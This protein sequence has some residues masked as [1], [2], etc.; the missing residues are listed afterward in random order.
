MQWFQGPDAQNV[1][2]PRFV[3]KEKLATIKSRLTFW[4]V[5]EKISVRKGHLFR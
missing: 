4:E 2:V 1:V 3:E 5:V